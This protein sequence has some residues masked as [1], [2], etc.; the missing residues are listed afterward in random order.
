[1]DSTSYDELRAAHRWEVPAQYNIAADVCDKHSRAKP[2]MVWDLRARDGSP[3]TRSA[4]PSGS[5][6]RTGRYS[7]WTGDVGTA[8]FAAA[9]LDVDAGYPI[10]DIV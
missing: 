10:L 6:L 2:A 1:V 5:A 8:L 7:R 9:C 3:S 4:R